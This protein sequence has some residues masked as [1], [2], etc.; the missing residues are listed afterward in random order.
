MEH[1]VNLCAAN[2]CITNSSFNIEGCDIVFESLITLSALNANYYS[3]TQLKRCEPVDLSFF[4]QTE[5]LLVIKVPGNPSAAL[6]PEGNSKAGQ[7]GE[8]DGFKE[9]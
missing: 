4:T 9:K 5:L 8:T 7:S 2:V 3:R 1:T 6:K